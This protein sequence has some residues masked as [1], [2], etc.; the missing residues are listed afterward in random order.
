MATP[1]FNSSIDL[2]VYPSEFEE[3]SFLD[4][5]TD[6]MLVQDENSE[7]ISSF[8]SNYNNPDTHLN[9]EEERDISLFITPLASTDSFVIDLNVD[10]DEEDQYPLLELSLD[11]LFDEDDA[12]STHLNSGKYIKVS[13]YFGQV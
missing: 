3:G 7:Q 13:V 4:L 1:N 8:E 12:D 9:L 2:N 6:P 10:P 11:N 5:N